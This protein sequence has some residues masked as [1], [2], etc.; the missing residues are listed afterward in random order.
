MRA[1]AARTDARTVQA[2]YVARTPRPP[3]GRQ[4]GAGRTHGFDLTGIPAS[5]APGG[6]VVG[7]ADA[8]VERE[9]DSVADRVLRR[10]RGPSLRR[11]SGGGSDRL[12]GSPAPPVVEE[13]L[14]QPGRPLDLTVRADIEPRFGRSFD[15]VRIHDDGLA[16]RSARAVDARAY[17]VGHHVAF[18][19]DSY[20]PD[21]ESG[22]RL[23]VHELAH[24]VQQSASASPATIRRFPY[25][26]TAVRFDRS[27][28][29]STLAASYWVARTNDHY[30]LFQ[31]QR[32]I[33][34]RAEQDAVLAALWASNPPVAVARDIE[35]Q[36]TVQ[37][38]P[39]NLAAR[40]SPPLLYRFRFNPPA[41]PAAKP[42][43]IVEFVRE[44]GGSMPPP[45]PIPG[46]FA[47]RDYW[48]ST[49]DNLRDSSRP[50]ADRLGS[51]R[52]PPGLPAIER[53]A[54]NYAI[55]SYFDLGQARNTEV[56]AVVPL[57]AGART[58]LV[59]LRFGRIT[60]SSSSVSAKAEPAPGRSTRA[61]ST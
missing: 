49:L 60:T 5:P 17:T 61:G 13:M 42:R 19:R 20:A 58:L 1:S 16:D 32:M 24:V 54:I 47:T 9:A 18:A 28:N 39:P 2:A 40:P 33:D 38:P 34:D 25:Q 14:A 56:D 41:S 59:T 55:A 8:A 27:V 35:I 52:M 36:V 51:V 29:A 6:L 37:A 7:A 10:E 11:D 45:A 23:L 43:L 53:H 3:A 21:E 50:A 46:D 26:T 31:S 44:G 12:A 4:A 22:R 57:D 48:E 15:D 30:E